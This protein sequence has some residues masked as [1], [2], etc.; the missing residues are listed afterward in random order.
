[1]CFFYISCIKI[2]RKV[3]IGEGKDY[4]NKELIWFIMIEKK[5][6]IIKIRGKNIVVFVLK[7]LFIFCFVIKKL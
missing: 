5:L 6:K 1:M 3:L 2:G 4:Y 7:V